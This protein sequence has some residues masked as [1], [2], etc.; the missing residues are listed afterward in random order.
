MGEINHTYCRLHHL[1]LYNLRCHD[2]TYIL[3]P[4]NNGNNNNCYNNIKFNMFFFT[5]YQQLQYTFTSYSS[6][7]RV[8][9]SFSRLVVF[10]LFFFVEN[11]ENLERVKRRF[12]KRSVYNIV[13]INFIFLIF[14][15]SIKINFT[16]KYFNLI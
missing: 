11:Y 3:Q 10:F 13:L 9:G 14:F 15:L 16:Y 5:N 1:E 8:F 2:T 4:N 7:E 6:L 12:T